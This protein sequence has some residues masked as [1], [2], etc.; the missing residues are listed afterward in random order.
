V[1]FACARRDGPTAHRCESFGAVG[2]AQ[3]RLNALRV[4]LTMLREAL[5]EVA[6][7]A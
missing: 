6:A 2:R 1:H 4:A 7:A 3:V 5:S